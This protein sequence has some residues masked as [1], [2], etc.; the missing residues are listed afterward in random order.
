MAET[1]SLAL[2]CADI[3][4]RDFFARFSGVLPW[5]WQAYPADQ[6]EGTA[7]EILDL[8]RRHGQAVR[9]LLLHAADKQLPEV[10]DQ[11]LSPNSLLALTLK[12]RL[13]DLPGV[14][15]DGI[16]EP[17]IEPSA[18][19]DVS[20]PNVD[21]I[22]I[23]IDEKQKLILI[24]N[25]PELKGSAIFP[26]V[27]LLVEISLEDRSKPGLPERYRLPSR[28]RNRRSIAVFG[29]GLHPRGHH[30]RTRRTE[31]SLQRCSAGAVTASQALIETTS[32]GY[33]LNPEVRIVERRDIDR[34]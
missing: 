5:V 10:I 9:Q 20:P 25:L 28:A 18:E 15:V 19:P 17:A 27:K 14:I 21:E 13:F 8:F 22:Q 4:E 6:R 30:A 33:R 31:E 3:S 26:I 34:D 29:R 7:K 16:E 24:R 32:Q 12:N 23:A 2:E 1:I 11:T